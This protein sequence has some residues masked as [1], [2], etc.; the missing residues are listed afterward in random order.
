RFVG[1][2]VDFPS[3]RHTSRS[4]LALM[5]TLIALVGALALCIDRFHN[6]DFYLSLGSGRW[7]AEHGFA[8]RDPF[9]TIA[10]GGTW[11]NQ[12]W[13]SELTFFRASQIVGPTGLTILYALLL[14]APL[15][16]LLWLCRSKG[17]QMMVAISA[18]YFPGILAIV[19]PRAAGFTVLIFSV[20]V[21]LVLAIWRERAGAPANERRRW[22]GMLA[23]LGLFA[24]W[25]NLH[26]GFV[27]GLLLL[28]LVTL[29]LAIDR[30]RGIPDSV[31]LPRVLA[32]GLLALLAAVTVT[33]AT[34]LGGQI[35]SYLL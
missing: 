23:I 32:L 2:S 31:P 7:I 12:Q 3:A 29:G 20:L 24:L 14:A 5:G 28:G 19:N 22:W 11:L 9:A 10:H 13:L 34:P 1:A 16:V 30:W 15:A 21:A 18:F 8:A 17:W 27:A 4:T 6:G 35:W 33:I 25:A 26:G